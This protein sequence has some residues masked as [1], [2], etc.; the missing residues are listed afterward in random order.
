MKTLLSLLG[1]G[2]ITSVHAQDLA[3]ILAPITQPKE[4]LVANAVASSEVIVAPTVAISEEDITRALERELKSHLGLE[5]DLRIFLTQPWSNLQVSDEQPWNVRILQTPSGGLGSTAIIRFRIE[6]G[7][8]RIGEWNTTV[9]AQLWRNV[10]TAANRIERGRAL[11]GALCQQ[12]NVDMLRENQAFIPAD[13]DITLYEAAQ[14]I[15]PEQK[16]TWRDLSAYQIIRKG[17]IVEVI[18]NEGPMSITLKGMALSG[19]GIGQEI[20]VRNVESRRD[21]PAR[22]VDARAVRVN[23]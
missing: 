7:A 17:Q 8:T 3:A 22:I 15:N 21:I 11:N 23:F 4:A 9:R 10:W 13:T 20:M 19:G 5:G 1:I 18:A 16:L 6:A 12:I 14:N 2:I